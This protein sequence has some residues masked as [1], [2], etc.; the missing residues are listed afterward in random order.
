[1][2]LAIFSTWGIAI[3]SL[4]GLRT[5]VQ[6]AVSRLVKGS[7][8]AQSKSAKTMVAK[9][10]P[11]KAKLTATA[12]RSPARAAAARKDVKPPAKKAPVKK[13]APAKAAPVKKVAPAKKVSP[14]RN[15]DLA[16]KAAP[17]KKSAPKNVVSVKKAKAAQPKPAPNKAPV[18]KAVPAKKPIIAKSAAK[19]A[20]IAKTVETPKQAASVAEK[21]AAAPVRTMK[22]TAPKLQV[23]TPVKK[24]AA[25]VQAPSPRSTVSAQPQH[26]NGKTALRRA[27]VSRVVPSRPATRPQ[28]IPQDVGTYHSYGLGLYYEEQG[29]P[30]PTVVPSRREVLPVAVEWKERMRPGELYQIFKRFFEAN[31]I[32]NRLVA[33]LREGS[34]CVLEF[35][36]DPQM[37][38]VVKVRGRALFESGRPAK[39]EVYLKLSRHAVEALL[40]L[41][42]NR[43][44]AYVERFIA[45][46]EEVE[47]TQRIELKLLCSQGEAM[48]K[49]YLG[50]VAAGGRPFADSLARMNYA[51]PS[52]FLKQL[53]ARR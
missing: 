14:T 10:K 48:R 36:G 30:Y 18:E 46:L 19:P 17:S 20:T 24:S 15:A 34:A 32:G 12:T 31:E 27:P 26:A 51:F 50:I 52:G 43:P 9:A 1:M 21:P 37:Y 22:T 44:E 38:K 2:I 4:R 42:M 39:A 11:S 7:S 47:P 41:E 40:A 33:S 25:T 5:K 49:G 6:S 8:M 28:P 29:G 45:L 13:A 53:T 35:E 3:K 16:K 23:A